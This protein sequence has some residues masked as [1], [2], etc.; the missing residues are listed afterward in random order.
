[1]IDAKF[2]RD[3]FTLVTITDNPAPQVHPLDS[4]DLREILEAVKSGAAR[5]KGP[6]C[7][8]SDNRAAWALTSAAALITEALKG[9]E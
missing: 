9:S 2:M 4:E 7:E 3:H 6:R 1:M 5:L 8:F